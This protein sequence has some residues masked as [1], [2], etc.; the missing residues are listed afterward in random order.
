MSAENSCAYYICDSSSSQGGAR[1]LSPYGERRPAFG[2][3]GKLPS[4]P[5]SMFLLLT[6]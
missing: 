3:E 6:S 1:K 5:I 4:G 2:P